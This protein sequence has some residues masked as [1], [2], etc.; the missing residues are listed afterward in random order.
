LH[1]PEHCYFRP[2][3]EESGALRGQGAFPGSHSNR[4]EPQS[5]TCVLR[6]LTLF[7][8]STLLED[9]LD[10]EEGSFEKHE[11]WVLLLSCTAVEAGGMSLRKR[12]GKEDKA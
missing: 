9:E 3:E 11:P 6:S 2:L 8:F 1:G 5:G 10:Q 7:L 4:K 12:R